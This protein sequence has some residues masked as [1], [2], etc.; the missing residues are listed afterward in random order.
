M[1]IF[2]TG[3][4][5]ESKWRIF[6]DGTRGC[7]QNITKN[8]L[9]V[10]TYTD[11]FLFTEGETKEHFVSMRVRLITVLVLYAIYI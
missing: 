1:I 10:K 6:I 9:S 4:I 3:V 11:L 2:S 7:V 5:N 8:Y